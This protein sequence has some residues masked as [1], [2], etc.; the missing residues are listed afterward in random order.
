MIAAISRVKV[1]EAATETRALL[2]L[3]ISCQYA[4]K[5]ENH[6]E[7]GVHTCSCDTQVV[8][9]MQQVHGR[10]PTTPTCNKTYALKAPVSAAHG[11]LSS[12]CCWCCACCKHV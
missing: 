9:K 1:P 11:P 6:N 2:C 4:C 5:H 3:S 8:S 10:V 12:A 7:L